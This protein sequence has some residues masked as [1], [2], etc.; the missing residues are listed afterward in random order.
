MINQYLR[1]VLRL[2]GKGANVLWSFFEIGWES[3]IYS[4]F[5]WISVVNLGR[6]SKALTVSRS[7]SGLLAPV[8]AEDTSGLE[9]TQAIASWAIVHPSYLARSPNLFKA[10]IVCSFLSPWKNPWKTFIISGFLSSLL[11]SGIPLLY[12]PVSVPPAKGEKIVVPNSPFSKSLLYLT[13]MLSLS[14]ILYWGC[15][16]TGLMRLYFSQIICASAIW[17]W[18]HSLVPQ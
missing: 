18:H 1:I 11:P 2:L 5:C 4:I 16:T 12:F 10:A 17:S 13:S 3:N 6:T 9:M 15:S 7:W 8:I 14:K